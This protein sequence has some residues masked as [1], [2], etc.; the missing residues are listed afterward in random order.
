MQT[1]PITELLAAKADKSL[2]RD[3]D[4]F[5][6]YPI[7]FATPDGTLVE[8]FLQDAETSV[9]GDT[10]ELKAV[11]LHSDRTRFYVL[12]KTCVKPPDCDLNWDTVH[13]ATEVRVRY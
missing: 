10:H 1:N 3:D 5:E 11:V 9:S 8:G 6:N 12:T 7:T 2:Y 4:R 13:C